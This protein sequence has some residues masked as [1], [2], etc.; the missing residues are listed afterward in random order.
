CAALAAVSLHR[1][2]L[3]HLALFTMAEVAWARLASAM[4]A[5]I[6]FPCR[7]R[8]MYA[9]SPVS[10]LRIFGVPAMSVVGTVAVGS[11]GLVVYLL[12][13]DPVAAGPLIK[14]PLPLEFWIVVGTIV[15]GALWYA[16]VKAYRRRSGI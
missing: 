8:A 9:S 11:I 10:R 16:G 2:E 15:A 12:W 1:S 3:P 14:S 7:R 5:A 13:R 6:I 4:F